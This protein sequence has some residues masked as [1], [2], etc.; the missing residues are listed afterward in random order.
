M[1]FKS[2][3]EMAARAIVEGVFPGAAYA[4]GH[5][6]KVVHRKAQGRHTYCPE[7]LP[8]NEDTVWDLAS[9]SKVIGTTTGAMWLF[10]HGKLDFD[11]PIA[12]ILPEFGQNDKSKITIRNLLTHDSGLVAFRGYHLTSKTPEE[13]IGKIF[14]EKLAFPIGSKMV[15]SDLGMITFGKV[16][17]ALSGREF[18]A[19]LNE[20]VFQPLG[21]G[22]TLYDPVNQIRQRC[23]PTEDIPAWRTNLR[24][25]RG[26]DTEEVRRIELQPNGSSY[27]KGEV[28]DP[29]AM[30]LGGI[31]GHA[32][33]FSVLDD[34]CNYMAMILEKGKSLIKKETVE[35]FTRRQSSASSRGLGWDTND[36]H[37]A[38]AGSLFSEKS[39]GHTGYTGTSI[40]GDP[41]DDSFVVL[42]TNR[43]HPTSENGKLI[44]WRAKFHDEVYRAIHG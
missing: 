29:N 32:G 35:L 41:E 43:V 10:D 27:I 12:E 9:V 22:T 36:G 21:M 40:W 31:A 33:L 2:V 15:Y 39:F 28:H 5:K 6:G 23:A 37:R 1:N 8:T 42:L 4:V 17:E 44:P 26:R 34:L 24:K 3:D 16:V 13:V 30:V 25:L 18:T 19:F 11:Q 38:S 14:A 20:A 7:S